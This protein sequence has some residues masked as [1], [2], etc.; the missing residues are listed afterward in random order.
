MKTDYYY[1]F[2]RPPDEEEEEFWSEVFPSS[3]GLPPMSEFRLPYNRKLTDTPLKVVR[4]E[5]NLNTY[6]SWLSIASAL[7][8][9][10]DKIC[11]AAV[12]LSVSSL[13][14]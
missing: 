6:K 2:L 10:K 3:F 8:L 13:K 5:I 9:P 12:H 4:H 1:Y 7:N 14:N 11:T